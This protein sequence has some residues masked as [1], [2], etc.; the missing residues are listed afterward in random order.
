MAR[1]S[2]SA[3]G[4]AM[5]ISVAQTSVPEFSQAAPGTI[6]AWNAASIVTF[7]VAALIV[8]VLLGGGALLF[9]PGDGGEPGVFYT[10][11]SPNQRSG[12]NASGSS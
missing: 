7:V 8:M 5:E 6:N 10:G 2:G 9:C 12:R 4:L 1:E 11:A 3:P